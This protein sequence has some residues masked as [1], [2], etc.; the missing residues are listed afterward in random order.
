[1]DD[2]ALDH[3]VL[4]DLVRFDDRVSV[5]RIARMEKEHVALVAEAFPF[6][7]VAFV[8]RG[9]RRVQCVIPTCR[10]GIAHGGGPFAVEVPIAKSTQ[11][12]ALTKRRKAELTVLKW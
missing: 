10:S 7:F 11:I 5:F 8:I 6:T 12:R 9:A 4:E 2:C 3:G 1:M